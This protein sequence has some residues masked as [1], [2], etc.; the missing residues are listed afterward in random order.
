[1]NEVSMCEAT[2]RCVL[3]VETRF[4]PDVRGGD[5]AGS[6]PAAAGMAP[7]AMASGLGLR[8]IN[9]EDPL[10]LASRRS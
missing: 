5:P 6:E 7:M 8:E 9:G 1:M 2:K 4:W 3:L 10:S